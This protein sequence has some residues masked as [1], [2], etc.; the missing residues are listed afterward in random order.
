MVKEFNIVAPNGVD[1]DLYNSKRAPIDFDIL[2]IM[3]E[4]YKN[5]PNF[6]IE[7]QFDTP[8]AYVE[9]SEVSVRN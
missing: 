3:V 1:F 6:Y 2:S 5:D 7:V 4:Q 8:D 9:Q